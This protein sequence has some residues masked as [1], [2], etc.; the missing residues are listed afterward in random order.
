MKKES[1]ELNDFAINCMAVTAI[2]FF[3]VAMSPLTM[4]DKTEVK[5]LSTAKISLPHEEKYSVNIT[6]VKRKY[7][8]HLFNTKSE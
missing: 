4:T 5:S 2:A 7:L 6:N 3:L 1:E 8:D